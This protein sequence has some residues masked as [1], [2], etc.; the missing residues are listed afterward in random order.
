MD[1]YLGRKLKMYDRLDI[2]RICI[3][4][5]LVIDTMVTLVQEISSMFGSITA[6]Y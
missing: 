6:E 2:E 3:F 5:E 1:V 4:N